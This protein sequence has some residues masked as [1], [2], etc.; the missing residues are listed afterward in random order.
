MG[1]SQW[2]D[3]QRAKLARVLLAFKILLRIEVD[4]L[5]RMSSTPN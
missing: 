1:K 5:K 4:I 2:R 3:A